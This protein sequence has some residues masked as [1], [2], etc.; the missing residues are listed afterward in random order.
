MSRI[1]IAAALTAI[2]YA[3]WQFC[4]GQNEAAKFF[5]V[6]LRMDDGKSLPEKMASPLPFDPGFPR[7]LTFS[8]SSSSAFF[9]QKKLQ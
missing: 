7:V 8:T 4:E 6:S 1:F 3:A 5:E 9:Y 2:S